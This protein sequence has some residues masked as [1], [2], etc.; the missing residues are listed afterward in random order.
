VLLWPAGSAPAK[1]IQ[2]KLGGAAKLL[3]H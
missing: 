2:V 3:S 1:S